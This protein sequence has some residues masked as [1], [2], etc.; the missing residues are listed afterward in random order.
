M[1]FRPL[2]DRVLVK[3]LD[4]AQRSTGGLFLPESAQEKPQQAKVIAVGEGTRDGD[5]LTPPSVK[6]GDTVLFGKFTGEKITLDGVE[7]LIL[8]EA[9]LLGVID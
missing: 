1:S 5:A 3:R 9:D 6:V 7:H 4:A 8:R 2:Q